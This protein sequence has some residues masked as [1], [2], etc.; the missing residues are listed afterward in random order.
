MGAADAGV[1]QVRLVITGLSETDVLIDALQVR[2]LKREKALLGTHI[3]CPVGGASGTPRQIEIELQEQPPLTRY[4]AEGG[5]S[6][7]P[8]LFILRK[9][10]NEV[11]Y[12]SAYAREDAYDWIAD[13]L[14]LVNGKRHII[15]IDNDGRSF[16]T[17]ATTRAQTAY[18][19]S[20][21]WTVG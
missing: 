6:T 7:E 19:Y 11:F 10:E 8:F 18:W 16:R 20:G 12:L 5:E 13:L 3:V 1:T 4:V 9:G 15:R 14:L 2:V 21:R 17:T